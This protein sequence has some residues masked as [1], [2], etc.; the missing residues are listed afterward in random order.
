MGD[1]DEAPQAKEANTTD[2]LYPD[3]PFMASATPG[4]Q[5][6]RSIPVQSQV[7][8]RESSPIKSSQPRES[9]RAKSRTGRVDEN[10]PW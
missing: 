4:F 9:S 7:Q 3:L 1:D 5:S 8:L 10:N 6:L 2:D